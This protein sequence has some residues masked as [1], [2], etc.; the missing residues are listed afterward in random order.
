M[1]SRSPGQVLSDGLGRGE[2]GGCYEKKKQP[3]SARKGVGI[4]ERR[5]RGGIRC[6]FGDRFWGA[7]GGRD[8]RNRHGFYSVWKLVIKDSGKNQIG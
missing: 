4:G 5:V 3:R 2:W 8:R 6:R 7:R 1:G